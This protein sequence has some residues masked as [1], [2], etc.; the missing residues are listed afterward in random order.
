MLARLIPITVPIPI[1]ILMMATL[2]TV[3]LVPITAPI[4]FSI[5]TMATLWITTLVAIMSGHC[6]RRRGWGVFQRLQKTSLEIQTAPGTNDLA[7]RRRRL[8]DL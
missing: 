3:I 1:S 4:P 7:K 6:R 2:W 5:L 8:R